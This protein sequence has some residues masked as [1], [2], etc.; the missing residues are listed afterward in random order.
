[1]PKRTQPVKEQFLSEEFVHESDDED[2]PGETSK[3]P[4]ADVSEEASTHSNDEEET[5]SSSE[6]ESATS[7][8]NDSDD[9]ELSGSDDGDAS[10][11]EGSTTSS[12]RSKRGLDEADKETNEHAKRRRIRYVAS[13][14][15]TQHY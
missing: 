10:D 8:E 2:A 12:T 7:V 11:Q 14:R 6:K 5:P 15:L 3:S 4:S 1:M 9:A 13:S